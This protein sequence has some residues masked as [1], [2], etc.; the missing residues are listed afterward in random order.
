MTKRIRKALEFPRCKGRVVVAAFDGGAVTSDAGV[1]LLRQADRRLGLMK[2]IGRVIPDPR[3]QASC[4][5]DLLSL[6]RQRVYGIALGDEDLNDHDTLRNDLA[7]QTAVDRAEPLA[8]APTLC[9]LE[10]RADR[11]TAWAMHEVLVEKFIA[12]FEQ[13]P[14]EIV[15]DFDATDD[16]VHGAQEGRFFN[17]FYN[18]YC[19]LPLYVFSGDQLLVAYLRQANRGGAHHAGAV[20][21]LLLRRLRQAW[22][23][24]RIV[25]RGDSHFCTPRIL[26][27]CDR[28]GVDYIVG[29]AK[30]KRL[31]T[32]AGATLAKAARRFAKT[33]RKARLFTGFRY[34]TR[35]WKRKRR[36]IARIEHDTRGSNPRYV[37]TRLTGAGRALY[38]QVYCAR[39]EMENR[40]KEQLQLFSDRT[41]CHEWWPNQFRLL[42]SSLAYTL[43]EAMRRLGLAGTELARAQVATIRLKLLKIGAV[44][45]RNTR[46][47]RFLLSSAYP[48]Q[49]LFRRV[50][51]NLAPS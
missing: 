41:S 5:H 9:R 3:R 48:H 42:L 2:Q 32:L 25:F 8:S 50:A 45:V 12:S 14:Q 34:A 20:L 40:I 31:N 24:V 46:R 36:V 10:N 11:E 33:G 13:A 17:G 39:G 37:V 29:L 51:E 47:V 23:A 49:D 35:N 18:E 16:P 22:P 28:N 6:L 38:E 27:F 4:T 43:L 7:L 15:L 26:G 30:N 1:L 19:F 21:K 44:I